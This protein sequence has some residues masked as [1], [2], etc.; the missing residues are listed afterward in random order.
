MVWYIVY[1]IMGAMLLLSLYISIR[2]S[3]NE[4]KFPIGQ[5]VVDRKTQMVG[6]IQSVENHFKFNPKMIIRFNMFQVSLTKRRKEL[7]VIKY[8]QS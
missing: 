6:F 5:M 4:H 8:L 3:I 7:K 2:A 1:S